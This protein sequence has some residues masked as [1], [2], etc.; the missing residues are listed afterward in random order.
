MFSRPL[1]H[2]EFLG[3]LAGGGAGGDKSRGYAA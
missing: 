2:Q 1:T 3:E